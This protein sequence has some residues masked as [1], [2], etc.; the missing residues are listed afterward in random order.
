MEILTSHLFFGL[1]EQVTTLKSESKC[2]GM[3]G[4]DVMIDGSGDLKL[5]EVTVAPDCERA[6]RDYP[7][8]WNESLELM[9]FGEKTENFSQ[10]F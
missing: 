4:I 8:F 6:Q 7:T 9:A 1:G 5:L 10:V 2:M 3:F